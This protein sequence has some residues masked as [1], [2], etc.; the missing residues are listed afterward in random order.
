MSLTTASDSRRGIYSRTAFAR[1]LL[2][3]G[4][5]GTGVQSQAWKASSN[6]NLVGLPLRQPSRA[7]LPQFCCCQKRVPRCSFSI[8]EK[9]VRLSG[10]GRSFDLKPIWS[11]HVLKPPTVGSCHPHWQTMTGAVYPWLLAAGLQASC[12]STRRCASPSPTG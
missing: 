3:A 2:R 5:S 12:C 8:L 4:S 9:R 11:G 6:E 10:F 7:L 1:G